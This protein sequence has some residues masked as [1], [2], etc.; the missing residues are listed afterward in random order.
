MCDHYLGLILDYMDKYDL[1][2]DTMLIVNTD[3]G[4]MLGEHNFN[5]KNFG[6]L[7]NEVSHL[8]FFIYNPKTK[9]KGTRYSLS[10]TVDI[11]PTLLDFFNLDIPNNLDGHSLLS[12]LENDKASRD[13][14]YF[15]VFGSYNCAT[16]GEMVY[17]HANATDDNLPLVECTLMPTRMRGYFDIEDIN[18]MEISN[19]DRHSNN[20][21]YMKIPV[22]TFY[23]AKITGNQLFDLKNDPYQLNNLANTTDTTKY[24]KWI[25]DGLNTCE[26]PIEEYIR[27]GFKKVEK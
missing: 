2:K 3:H 6:P 11:A 13:I 14:A 19:G 5:G 23:N 9:S 4:F 17:M 27:L 16:N 8:P 24:S 25:L 1:W 20:V 21:K 22:K 7:Y 15:G 10:Q 26:A 12:T 18:N